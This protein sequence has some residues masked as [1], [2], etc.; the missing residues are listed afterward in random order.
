[1]RPGSS[2]AWRRAML[3]SGLAASVCCATARSAPPLDPGWGLP[4]LMR[5]LA[6]VRSAS[7]RFTERKTMRM[8]KAPLVTAGTVKYVAPDQLWKTTLSPQR[9]RFALDGCQVTISGG[10]DERTRTFSLA[11]GPEIAG[12]VE[13]IRATLA[14]D[15]PTLERF[16]DVRLSGD[17][18]E[19]QLVLQPKSRELARFISWMRIRGSRE[20]VEAIDT[21]SGDGDH[22]EM[23]IVED[24][25][26]AG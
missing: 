3:C 21:E 18:A 25:I 7:A 26:D 12:L 1:M 6:E 22:S 14:G 11:A 13:G 16:Y 10:P 15:L 19:W 24:V 8:L 9:E 20:R 2:S 4:Q 17:N 23:T 5:E